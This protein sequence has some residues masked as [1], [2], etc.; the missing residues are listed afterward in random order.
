MQRYFAKVMNRQVVL[1]EGDQYHLLKVMRARVGDEV[2]IVAEG[3]VYLSQVK[4]LKPLQIETLHV[5]K[6]NNELKNDVV[7]IVSLLKGEK[8]DLVL[9]KATEL[10][11]EEIV[12]LQSERS[13]AKIRGLDKDYKLERFSRIV[14]EAAEQSKRTR[15][16]LVYRVIKMHDLPEVEADICLIAYEGAQGSSASFLKA[17]KKA[18]PGQRI[19][20][21]IGPE[22][23]FSPEEVNEATE[24]GYQIVSL[25]RR[26]LRAETASFYAMSVLA[27]YLER[28]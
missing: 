25:G 3:R 1:D 24:Y 19:S 20:I 26:I 18:T 4:C 21:L 2:E 13:I 14:K 5:I 15:I 9:Q 10:G 7:L 12:L 17:I 28:K 8:L 16:P 11:V 22:G 6:E 27:S 23:G